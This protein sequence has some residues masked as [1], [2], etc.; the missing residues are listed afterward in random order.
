[1]DTSFLCE[2]WVTPL[3]SLVTLGGIYY[4]IWKNSKEKR[5]TKNLERLE[6][7][8]KLIRE[9]G[10]VHN[11]G[12]EHIYESLKLKKTTLSKEN[13]IYIIKDS[14]ISFIESHSFFK[15]DENKELKEIVYEN[16][17]NTDT[18]DCLGYNIKNALQK[19]YLE[20][21]DKTISMYDDVNVII[22]VLD[23]IRH[24]DF[25]N[26][27][28]EDR[29]VVI[30][31]VEIA[32][33]S[34]SYWNNNYYKWEKLLIA[35]EENLQTKKEYDLKTEG[36]KNKRKEG[37]FKWKDV[38]RC[39]IKGAANGTISFG[40]KAAIIPSTG[41]LLA[42]GATIAAGAISSS[43]VSAGEQLIDR[44]RTTRKK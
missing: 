19:K 6:E 17:R 2:C 24:L 34:I 29:Y 30:S 22:R 14:T 4:L 41:G 18:N 33:A 12:L 21:I 5:G 15:S 38:G 13:I 8:E 7:F 32:K 40:I 28:M 43:A 10:I 39:D 3:L 9:V 1:M 35:D 25:K 42:L 37:W 26:F 27:N 20:Y 23:N 16:F 36:V 31:S 11:E 44:F